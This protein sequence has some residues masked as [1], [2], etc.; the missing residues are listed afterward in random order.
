ML[1]SD[2]T[3]WLLRVGNYLVT[4]VIPFLS[5]FLVAVS[6]HPELRRQ[7]TNWEPAVTSDGGQ[8]SKT[9]QEQKRN[10]RSARPT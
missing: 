9:K 10:A 1:Q 7:I 6:L 2:F 3:K 5:P 4:N 8:P